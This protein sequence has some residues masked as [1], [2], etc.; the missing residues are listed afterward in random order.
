MAPGARLLTRTSASSISAR[1]RVTIARRLQVE[2]DA[3]LPRLSQAKYADV[4]L[5]RTVIGPRRI[6]AVRTFDLDHVGA[7]VGELARA[8]RAGDRLL[9]RDDAKP[10]QAASE[11]TSAVR[12]HVRRCTRESC[13]SRSA[14]PDRASSRE[15]CVR[16][17]TPPRTQSR[18]TSAGRRSPPPTTRRRREA[19]PCL[20][21][22]HT[23]CL[24]S[25]SRAAS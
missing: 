15:T 7:K 23:A 4:P 19:W 11:T 20:L 21:R 13:S 16:R 2:H 5:Q 17:R 18:R 14:R 1:A 24:S 3:R 25:N 10:G 9:E 22:R 8:E 12:A 6:A